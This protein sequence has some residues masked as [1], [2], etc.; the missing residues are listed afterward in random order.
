MGYCAVFGTLLT[1]GFLQLFNTRS[2]AIVSAVSLALFAFY[3]LGLSVV[4]GLPLTPRFTLTTISRYRSRKEPLDVLS[5]YAR[6]YS[7]SITRGFP[8][9][10]FQP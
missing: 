3:G 1:M 4:Q 2:F 10:S 7:S 6:F 8:C 9:D 5:S